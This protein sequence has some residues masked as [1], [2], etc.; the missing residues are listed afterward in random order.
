MIPLAIRPEDLVLELDFGATA[1]ELSSAF[2][3]H[4]NLGI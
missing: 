3:N 1:A 2:N 4:Y